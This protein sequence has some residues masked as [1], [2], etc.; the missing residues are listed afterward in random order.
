MDKK[1]KWMF[2]L[3]TC[4]ILV[5]K[6]E[7]RNIFLTWSFLE[8]SYSLHY[9]TRIFPFIYSFLIIKKDLLLFPSYTTPVFLFLFIYLFIIIINFFSAFSQFLGL[10]RIK[11]ASILMLPHTKQALAR[12]QQA[13]SKG[14]FNDREPVVQ[15]G[16]WRRNNGFSLDP[17][18][19]ETVWLGV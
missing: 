18:E 14:N 5:N 1:I 13:S 7:L 16:S 6:E 2:S 11:V 12:A 8:V 15:R 4:G 19:G 3:I 9:L 10:R 17:V